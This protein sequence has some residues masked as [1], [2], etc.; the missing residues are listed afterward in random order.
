MPLE[1]IHSVPNKL[2]NPYNAIH[3]WISIYTRNVFLTYISINILII[4]S[5]DY[6][7]TSKR[8]LVIDMRGKGQVTTSWIIVPNQISIM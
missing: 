5:H 8:R 2:Y 4:Y 1:A 6:R 3:H 7:S